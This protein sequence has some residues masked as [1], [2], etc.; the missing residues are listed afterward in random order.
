MLDLNKTYIF[1]RVFKNIKISNFQ[2]VFPLVA[3]LF[4]ADRQIHKKKPV[5]A[6]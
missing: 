1:N 6:F 4:H 5:V 3:D 2:K